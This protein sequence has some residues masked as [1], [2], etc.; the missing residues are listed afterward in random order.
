MCVCVFLSLPV[1]SSPHPLSLS[2]S[3]C[4]SLSL[5]I[6]LSNYPWNPGWSHAEKTSFV[7]M[8]RVSWPMGSQ[9]RSVVVTSCHLRRHLNRFV[10]RF[11]TLTV[12]LAPVITPHTI[13]PEVEN[14]ELAKHAHYSLLLSGWV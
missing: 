3:V 4:L 10:T 7:L 9:N 6:S 1:F 14:M 8:R 13:G 11:H 12:V 2:L 5:S